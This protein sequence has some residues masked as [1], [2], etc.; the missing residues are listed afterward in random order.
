MVNWIDRCVALYTQHFSFIL[1]VIWDSVALWKSCFDE[2]SIEPPRLTEYKALLMI[3]SSLCKI[4]YILAARDVLTRQKLC[5]EVCS[6]YPSP[7]KSV[8]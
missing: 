3:D 5:R 4:L 8:L 1:A 7:S 2:Q 6:S